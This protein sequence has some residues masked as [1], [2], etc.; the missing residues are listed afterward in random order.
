MLSYQIKRLKFGLILQVVLFVWVVGFCLFLFRQP[1]TETGSLTEITNLTFTGTWQESENDTPKEFTDKIHFN[2]SKMKGLILKGHFNCF[3]PYHDQIHFFADRIHVVIKNGGLIACIHGNDHPAMMYSPGTDWCTFFSPLIT[4]VNTI[5]ITVTNADAHVSKNA[6]DKLISSFCTGDRHTL[7]LRQIRANRM[8]IFISLFILILGIEFLFTS[9]SL[10]LMAIEMPYGFSAC[11]LL[12]ICGAIT[13]LMN[14]QYITLLLQPAFLTNTVNFIVKMLVGEFLLIYLR[15]FLQKRNLNIIATS[16]I[17]GWATCIIVM[18]TLQVAGLIHTEDTYQFF[19]IAIIV[20]LFAMLVC[21]TIQ[22]L[23]TPNK[24][25][26]ILLIAESFLGIMTIIDLGH[27]LFTGN[28]STIFFQAGLLVFSLAQFYILIDYT[29]ENMSRMKHANELEK[30]LIQNK[31]SLMVSQIQPHFLYNSLTAIQQLC[32]VNPKLAV[33]AIDSFSSFLRGNIDS[34][35]TSKPIPF[36]KELEHVR[37]YLMIEQLRFGPRLTVVIDTPVTDFSIP[38]L[39][40][41]PVVENAVH[42][43]I[44]KREH[45]GTIIITTQRKRNS[46]IVTVHD[47]G[48]GYDPLIAP[49]NDK[50]SHVGLDNV[51]MRL[52]MQCGGTLEIETK[53]G[54]GTIV[55]MTIPDRINKETLQ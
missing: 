5:E 26:R 33:K 49:M 21:L 31:I 52:A 46:V 32:D 15:I 18:F 22:T 14:Q 3:I 17:H 27:F 35:S 16:L 51:R 55:T 47:N 50:K 40:V 13:T 1:H 30:Q 39:T 4:P 10:R 28:Y 19:L 42:Y 24:R 37:N 43:G 6:Y 23:S 20:I 48:T 44:T 8:Q 53:N 7:F 54:S 25:V 9:F 34:L 12:V 38:S 29:H 11:G 45:G 41:Q 2:A 36:E